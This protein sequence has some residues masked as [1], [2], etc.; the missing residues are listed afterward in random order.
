MRVAPTLG[1]LAAI[2]AVAGAA[3]WALEGTPR[4]G[5]LLVL[6]LAALAMAVLATPRFAGATPEQEGRYTPPQDARLRLVHAV[7]TVLYLM[8]IIVTVFAASVRTGLL[9]IRLHD[10]VVQAFPVT[11]G[12][13]AVLLAVATAMRIR[14]RAGV[15]ATLSVRAH[16]RILAVIG[17]PI[18]LLGIAFLF[19]SRL[20]LGPLTIETRDL[21]VLYLVGVLGVGTQLMLA[22]RLPTTADLVLRLFRST[23]R[24]PAHRLQE[25]PPVLYAV[26]GAIVA[27][28]V[29]GLALAEAGDIVQD[30]VALLLLVVPVGLAAFLLLS[31]LTI[32]REG[33]RNLYRRRIGGTLRA[34]IVAFATAAAGGL[35]FGGLLVAQATGHV[36]A[37]GPFSGDGL[38]KDLIVATILAVATPIGMHLHRVGRRLD[39]IESHLPDFLNDLAENR[40]A[41]LTLPAALLSAAQSDYG[42]LTPEVRHMAHQVAWGVPFN[43]ALA[44]FAKR[45]RSSLVKRSAHLIIE[46]S[47]TGGSVAE[48]LRA[49]ARDAYE[50]KAL[51]SE[52]RVTMMTYLIVL[53][54][55][56]FVFMVVVAVLDTKFIPEVLSA[57]QAAREAGSQGVS[58]V[59]VDA[60]RLQFVYFSAAIVQA[61][62]NG[63]VGGTLAEGRV[64]AGLRHVAIMT[65]IAWILF[66]LVLPAL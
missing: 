10:P 11:V 33:R 29:A 57:N 42:E 1:I 53:Y 46:S 52:R 44:A 55:V 17:G 37:I 7:V 15:A 32:A 65:A 23:P 20:A 22:V 62:G 56:F 59:N 58:F 36:T 2:A 12:L 50:I 5:A 9:D 39:G 63:I 24:R 25:T 14:E 48:I 61:V 43:D 30:R 34:R 49:A 13:Y 27:M 18:A 3:A 35:L 26:L 21:V 19:V 66:R 31:W 28:L 51:E 4:R 16:G 38:R 6:Y 47:R 60:A 8:G 45:I 54:V 40:R 41:G 64:S